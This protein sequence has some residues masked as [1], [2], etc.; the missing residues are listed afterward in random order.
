MV[1]GPTIYAFSTMLVAFVGGIA[2]GAS[3]GVRLA[4]VEA[5]TNRLAW[6]LLIAAA[7][8]IAGTFVV[9]RL[10]LLV[11]QWV[12]SPDTSFGTLIVTEAALASAMLLPT[13]IALGAAFPVGLTLVVGSTEL[14]LRPATCMPSTLPERSSDRSP[15]AF[16][17]IPTIGLRGTLFVAA[18]IAGA[19]AIAVAIRGGRRQLVAVAAASAAV[20]VAMMAAPR[21]NDALLSSGAYKYAAGLK[22]VDLRDALEAGSLLYYREGGAGTVSVRRSGGTVSLAIDGKVDASTGG[23]MLTQKLLAHLPLLHASGTRS[24][25]R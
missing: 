15:P 18:G 5:A 8:T 24:V 14:R 2:I 6:C 23:D 1:L 4:R 17:L 9:D 3:V 11:G 7:G 12:A 16:V 19:A 10:P 25:P 21:W 20:A 13:T 22:T